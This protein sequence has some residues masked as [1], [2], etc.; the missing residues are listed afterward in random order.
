M[1]LR[2]L[3]KGMRRRSLCQITIIRVMQLN[4]FFIL[5]CMLQVHAA[6][7][8]QS[9]INITK[10]NA[11]LR[12]V[13]REISK[14]TG[15]DFLYTS[16]VLS[17]GKRVS[18]D[19]K[20][21][22]L[23]DVLVKCLEDQPLNYTILD[24]TVVIKIQAP[25]SA[26]LAAAMA[27]PP[28][29][30]KGVITDENGSPI[31]GATIM[32]KG[33]TKGVVTATDGSF[34]IAAPENAVLVVSFMGFEPKEITVA[35]G[36]GP[37]NIAL[38]AGNTALTEYV[39]TA[40]GIKKEKKAL[41]YSIQ[42]VKGEDLTKAR[43]SNAVSGLTGKVAGLVITP[44][45]NLFGDPGIELRGR[46]NV[47]VVVDGVPISTDSWN[48]NA[49]DI[50]SYSVLKGA[51][52]AALY[53]QRGQNGAIVI[54]TKRAKS[55]KKGFQVDFNSSTQLQSGYNSIPKYQTE[56]GPGDDF[57]YAFK[58]GRGGGINDAD[59][60]IW[61]PRFEGQPITQYNSP[62]DP[63][64]GQLTPIPW[65]ARGKN[66]L[67]NYLRNGLLSTNNVAISTAND[68][69]DMRISF[70]QVAQRG[71][72][73]NTKYGSTSVNFNGGINIGEKLRV[74]G[75]INYSKQYT[76]NYPSLG[77]GPGSLIYLITVWGGVDYDI[78][79][80]RNY[81]QPGKE[82]VQQYNRE[83]TIYNN[84]WLIAN[85]A[86]HS[87][88]KDDIYGHLQLQYHISKKLDFKVRSNVST[89]NRHQAWRYPISA[90][91]YE[92]YRRVGGYREM[93]DYFWEN[94]TEGGFTYKD[95]FS[96]DFSF[97]GSLLANLRTVKVSSLS[98]ATKGGLITPG[99]Y[100]LGNS[101]EQNSPVND[102]AKRQVASGYGFIDMDWRS[103]I[104]L[105][106]T[107][108]FDRSST[109]PVKHNTYFYPSASLSIMLS[110]M[111]HMPDYVS[112]L[113]LRGAYANVAGDL[114]TTTDNYDIYKL[115]ANYTTIGTRWDNNVGI[116]YTGTRYNPDILPSR[117]KTNEVGL[118]GSFFGNRL[119]FDV[120][121]Y[122]NVEGPGI[123]NVTVSSASGVSTIQRNANTYIRK[124][125]EIT[126]TG[127]PVRKKDFSWDV[128]VN[129]STNQRWLKEIDGIQTR[130][131]MI[132]VGDRADG[133]YITDFQR[134]K[135]GQILVGNDGLP[136]YNPFQ[137]KIGYERNN[138]MMGVNNTFRYKNF[139][140]SI[141]VD[142]RF[143]GLINNYV[144]GYQWRS[145]TAPASASSYRYQ[146]WVHRDDPNW[147][148][149]VMTSGQKVISGK[150]NTDRDGNII[151]DDRK[152]A[153]NDVPVLW[154]D[155]ATD[156][157]TADRSLVHS[158]T[159]A[160]LREVILTYRVP[161][162]TLKRTNIFT[163]AS[164][165]LVGRNL[166]YFTSKYNKNIEL[167]QYT[168]DNAGFQTPSVKSYGVNINLSF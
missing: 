80:L 108:R 138:F 73:P 101:K 51:N 114:V 139:L 50:E 82:N 85:E 6:G 56:Y 14:Q 45:P 40:L 145:G 60:N 164:I 154:R 161:A 9:K 148:G 150:L 100:D 46:T 119:G 151:S 165:S 158:A 61:G 70:S 160:K 162:A 122:R 163:N 131:G 12:E 58:D 111:F 156:Y 53:G 135:D 137:T 7:F 149:T 11:T 166:L 153:P 155:W 95:K 29:D 68:K 125:G 3:I 112:M 141:Q 57:K 10:N 8:S 132:K 36:G 76:P 17:A 42:E 98:G 21:A 39:V 93:Y 35:A 75:A 102:Y 18:L 71:Q 116:T 54:T 30:V 4:T 94:N 91:F 109:M 86:T 117:V 32:V 146:D 110:E 106:L 38:K 152:Y 5:A 49:D 1:Y 103:M 140:L 127:A 55:N 23:K 128:M 77:Y 129:W 69:G 19:M 83:Y 15:Y 48:L 24:K 47:L 26:T 88:Y 159:F 130:T 41:G 27:V 123:V 13:F 72:V 120:A 34:H 157:Y 113:K 16:K 79:D 133:Y 96:K 44:S 90:D 66:N 33:T 64:T 52:A 31:P 89:W 142:G 63:V 97:T 144:D 107:G 2:T 124:G 65:L 20:D 43:E 143:G 115:L 25:G 62:K 67:T 81:W 37:L 121:Y 78:N 104:F 167:D 118:E 28:I 134:D 22:A 126:L 59:Y 168:T 87:Y 92:P 99:V 147:E 74:D 105:S 84:P 136:L